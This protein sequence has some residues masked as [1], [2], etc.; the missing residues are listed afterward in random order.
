[1]KNSYRVIYPS[2]SNLHDAGYGKVAHI[3]CIFDSRP[4]YHRT[5]SRFL[6]DRALGL[7]DPKN[8]GTASITHLPTK[9]SMKDYAERLANFLEWCDVRGLNPLKVDYVQ[10]LL[11]GYQ[12]E[13]LKGIWSRDNHPLAESSINARLNAAVDFCEWAHDKGLRPDFHVPK[14]T[15][16]YITQSSTSTISHLPKQVKVRQ[17]KLLQHK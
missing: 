10:N 15:H 4:G 7:W 8:K 9:Q 6:I 1:M 12:T 17:G 14:V 2:P 5:G 11:G 3:P 16:S 13:M